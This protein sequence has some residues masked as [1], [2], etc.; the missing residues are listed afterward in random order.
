MKYILHRCEYIKYI[1]NGLKTDSQ[2]EKDLFSSF[3]QECIE[4]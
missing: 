3:R 1:L 2:N 4:V